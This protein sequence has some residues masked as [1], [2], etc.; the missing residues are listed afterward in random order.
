MKKFLLASIF[1]LAFAA[2][3]R[4]QQPVQPPNIGVW[5]AVQNLRL[6][7]LH[8]PL[9]PRVVVPR[10]LPITPSGV[11]S[12]PLLPAHADA[13]DAGIAKKPSNAAVPIPKAHLPAPP[14]PRP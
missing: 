2:H 14:C 10:S 6:W 13:N 1:C 5:H 11:C 3:L 4:A 12:V 8:Q 7:Q 9:L